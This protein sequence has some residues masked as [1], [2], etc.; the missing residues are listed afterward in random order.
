LIC[1][2]SLEPNPVDSARELD[3]YWSSLSEEAMEHVVN[4]VQE[5]ADILACLL[6]S[7][8]KRMRKIG[9]KWVRNVLN[10]NPWSASEHLKRDA[11]SEFYPNRIRF[12]YFTPIQQVADEIQK[13]FL[14]ELP[15]LDRAAAW[16]KI[17]R[18]P[19]NFVDA[20]DRLSSY[21]RI[22]LIRTLDNYNRLKHGSV[23]VPRMLRLLFEPMDPFEFL[24]EEFA[25]ASPESPLL[26]F[27]IFPM[28][29]KAGR[30]TYVGQH[31]DF[32]CGMWQD[33]RYRREFRFALTECVLRPKDVL[34]NN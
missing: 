20:I 33:F 11:M 19:E 1:L 13:F 12:L 28:E 27:S 6:S 4:L 24:P 23:V 32:I 14:S 25:V 10:K 26:P 3:R 31:I 16:P 21:D 29:S 2:L 8:S 22:E 17:D 9:W 15:W 7:K 18:D 30:L 34:S 5:P